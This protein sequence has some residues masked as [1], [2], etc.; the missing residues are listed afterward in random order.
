MNTPVFSVVMPVYNV[1]T[2]VAEAIDT[3][4][5]QTFTDF[6]LIIVDDG[7]L[8]GSMAICRSYTDPRI[9]IVTQENRG[10]AGARNTGIAAARGEFVALLDSDDRWHPTKL[11]LHYIHLMASSRVDVSYSGSRLIDE[12]GEAMGVTQSPRLADVAPRH[13][14]LRNPVGNGSAAV[15][16]RRALDRVACVHPQEDDRICWFDESFRQSEDIE[17]WLRMSAEFGCVFEGIEGLLTE[18]RIV[19][20]GLSANM[21]RQFE[22]WERVIDKA[23]G[24]AP[25]LIRRHGAVARAYQLRYLARRAV[26]VGDGGF[27]VSLF[28][29]AISTS[30]TILLQEPLKTLETG[31]AALAAR[32]MGRRVLNQLAAWRLGTGLPA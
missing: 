30:V 32:F 25:E 14:L 1:E 15:I 9:R 28:R 16:R 31:L 7:G 22:S 13:I 5:A 29:E 2:Y 18:Y 26:Q 8:D 24:Y 23:R 21:V 4:L 12:R 11:A 17:L 27:A 20:G 10:L 6:E 19:G 3:V